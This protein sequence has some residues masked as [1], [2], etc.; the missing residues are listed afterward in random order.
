MF[1]SAKR[2]YK[3]F[4]DQETLATTSDSEGEAETAAIS[5][6][7]LEGEEDNLKPWTTALNG[8]SFHKLPMSIL[9]HMF[10]WLE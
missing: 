2:E 8:R 7:T 5:L 1:V 9:P 3:A 4:E 6:V 10:R